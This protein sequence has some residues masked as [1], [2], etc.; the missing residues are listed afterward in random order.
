MPS[1]TPYAICPSPSPLAVLGVENWAR[2]LSSSPP[3]VLMGSSCSA[4]EHVALNC[5]LVNACDI[6][7]TCKAD[8]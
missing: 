3:G 2:P 8:L 1:L 5:L 6:V 7:P 4:L